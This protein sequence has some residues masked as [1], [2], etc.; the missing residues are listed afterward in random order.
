MFTP[1]LKSDQV[2]NTRIQTKTLSYPRK[3]AAGENKSLILEPYLGKHDKKVEA[4]I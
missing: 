2:K 1:E 4:Q 3:W